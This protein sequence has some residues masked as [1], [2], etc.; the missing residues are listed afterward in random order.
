MRRVHYIAWR[1]SRL[2]RFLIHS[3]L[4]ISLIPGQPMEQR[5]RRPSQPANFCR[6]SNSMMNKRSPLQQHLTARASA[7]HG[8]HA[9]VIGGSLAGLLTARVLASHFEHVTVIE[10]DRLPDDPVPR[11]GVPQSRHIHALMFRGRM[12]LEEFFP[13]L[14]EE[15]VQAGAL[16]L[17]MAR[18]IRWLTPA[19]WGVRFRSELRI[20]AFT[21]D[22]LDWNVRRRIARFPNVRF[23]EEAEVTCL[24]PSRDASSVA[25]LVVRF[26]NR[27]D[28]ES[29][30]THLHADFVVDA[31]G[32]GSRAPQW[33]EA[34]GYGRPTE[35][36]INAYLGYASRLY[37]RPAALRDDAKA[38]FIQS[39]PPHRKRGGLLFPVEGH[40][41]LIT[42]VGGGR[43][44][45]PT[46]EAGF[47]EFLRSLPSQRLYEAIKDAEP[48]SPLYGHR[49]TENRLR[50]FERL[51]RWPENF[52]ILGDAACAFNPVYGQGMTTAALGVSKLAEVLSTLR[53]PDS[54]CNPTGLALRF[55]KQLAKINRAPW[56][57][58]TGQDY[59]YH[60]TVGGKRTFVTK[61]MHHY[62]D[63]IVQL[64]TES[65]EVRYALLVTFNMIKPPSALFRPD[66]VYR[67][68]KQALLPASQAEEKV[69]S[70][71]TINDTSL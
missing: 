68:L 41:W 10:R 16:D 52:V 30:S 57:M 67:V 45:P 38:I 43:D 8:S 32:R 13:G 47:L 26:R 12:I 61:L 64:S 39:A 69:F 58:S 65:A 33:L 24:L 55:Q 22:F 6:L 42:A 49:G 34:L 27:P 23:I 1:G 31:S 40:R 70:L 56:L 9:I 51:S 5:L 60:E 29:D 17:D 50:H 59:R 35:T 18:D 66:I 46:D 36:V 54:K 15:M 28:G 7:N 4:L 44:Y 14:Q 48:V 25:G 3:A 63:T 62:M 37:R 11:R 53:K 19:G 20:L 21:R 2:E 71:Q